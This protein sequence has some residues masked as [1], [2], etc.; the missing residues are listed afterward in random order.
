MLKFSVG[1]IDAIFGGK[2]PLEMKGSDGNIIKRTVTKRWLDKQ[3]KLG[4][5]SIVDKPIVRV[6]L[7]EPMN[8]QPVIEYW[9][10]GTDISQ[11][12]VNQFKDKETG[13]IYAITHYDKGEP[14]TRVITKDIW[15]VACREF[16]SI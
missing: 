16:M 12:I 8:L 14:R 11:E 9:K 7:L 10:V 4:K 6:H 3:V 15:D 1:I 5:M 13:A 2:I